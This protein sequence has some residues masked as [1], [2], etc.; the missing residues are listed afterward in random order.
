MAQKIPPVQKHLI[1]YIRA[2]MPARNVAAAD[3]FGTGI[4]HWSLLPYSVC[5]L[6]TTHRPLLPSFPTSSLLKFQDRG[7]ALYYV[8]WY[9]N[10]AVT[11]PII[12]YHSEGTVDTWTL[13]LKA[14]YL[15]GF[16][17][18]RVY[19]YYS[20]NLQQLGVTYIQTYV[21]TYIHAF[22]GRVSV[23]QRQ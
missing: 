9:R 5:C 3:V 2:T 19:Q 4:V 13:D 22:H 8:V 12:F 7:T 17:K 6:H 14:F 11:G 18:E 23:P 20:R 1:T 15:K 21:R 16:F 10:S